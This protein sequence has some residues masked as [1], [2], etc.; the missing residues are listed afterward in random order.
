M[1]IVTITNH[2][3]VKSDIVKTAFL[4]TAIVV[5]QIILLVLLKNHLVQIPNIQY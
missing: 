4:T 2:E 3:Q 5:V 1:H